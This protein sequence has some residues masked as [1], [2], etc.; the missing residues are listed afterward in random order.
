MISP[1]CPSNRTQIDII[2]TGGPDVG[3]GRIVPLSC[4]TY[5]PSTEQ[6]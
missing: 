4:V 5:L 3:T 1:E 2:F 6:K